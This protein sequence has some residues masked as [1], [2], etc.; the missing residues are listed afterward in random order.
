MLPIL[1]AAFLLRFACVD[2]ALP[3]VYPW[4]EPE[5]INPA[6]N[7]LRYGD[8][9]PARFAYG[10]INGYLHAA[11]G[12]LTFV[13]GIEK[14]EFPDSIWA[15]TSSR[16]TAWYWSITSAYFLRQARVL[17]VL[18]G[19]VS[20]IF[21]FAAGR[22]L[23]GV[24]VGVWAASVVALSRTSLIQTSTVTADSTSMTA[25]SIVVWASAHIFLS[26]ARWAYW[27]AAIGAAFAMAFKYTS[28]PVLLFPLLAH[29]VSSSQKERW[30]NSSLFWLITACTIGLA[31]LLFPV[32]LQP[33]RFLHDLASEAL[34]YGPAGTSTWGQ[35]VNGALRGLL[36]T[37]DAASAKNLLVPSGVM[38]FAVMLLGI[39]VLWQQNRGLLAMLFLPALLNIHFVAGHASRF[40]ERNLLLSQGPLAIVGGFGFVWLCGL[41]HS[42]L[43][44][45]KQFATASALTTCVLYVLAFL[46]LL[47]WGTRNALLKN[48][49]V[50]PRVELSRKMRASLPRNSRVLV[51]SETRWFMN[52]EELKHLQMADSP[53]LRM[54]A[55]PPPTTSVEYIVVP[56]EV[57][58]YKPT[59]GKQEFGDIIN[60]WLKKTKAE[61]GFEFGTAPM[62]FGKPSIFPAV[63]LVKNTESLWQTR[64]A[65]TDKIY[66]SQFT[67]GPRNPETKLSDE[68]LAI[69]PGIS[70]SATVT[71]SKPMTK[72]T[73]NA[74]GLSAQRQE[75]QPA[76]KLEMY[77][78]A[79][80]FNKPVA[81][82]D[83]MLGRSQGGL[84]DYSATVPVPPGEYIV[85]MRGS[86]PEDYR[87]EITL[88]S[89]S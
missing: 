6:I 28:F 1:A 20:V 22:R 17:S 38:L 34:Y 56:R 61:P 78:A 73:V 84:A 44:R 57:T 3:Y 25:T 9:R 54:L 69:R 66:G 11:W 29:F 33:T 40:F 13:R 43:S 88:V 41:A 32:F 15:L 27:V 5:I 62:F 23:G 55:E 53:I 77:P 31:L 52:R 35:Y 45:R 18:L 80:P 48:N 39:W 10:P 60:D 86:D 63:R 47:V 42:L 12:A 87:I 68:G 36:V 85:R 21:I 37:S 46:P 64:L 75:V 59:P 74:R 14:G 58:F 79:G 50:E 2:Y 4:D 70:I 30:L 67:A 76:L 16:D 26:R 82:A 24:A 8:Y 51:A 72:I 89:F 83:F 49:F 19:C 7:V 65:T 71:I 81:T